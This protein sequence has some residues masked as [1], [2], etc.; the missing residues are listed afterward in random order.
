MPNFPIFRPAYYINTL[1]KKSKFPDINSR[2]LTRVHTYL[3]QVYQSNRSEWN[4]YWKQCVHR[5]VLTSIQSN[6]GTYIN[7][8]DAV[9]GNMQGNTLLPVCPLIY[10][11]SSHTLFINRKHCKIRLSIYSKIWLPKYDATYA[12]FS[13][14]MWHVYFN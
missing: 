4:C 7:S 10:L 3:M 12:P 14:Y 1:L 5:I 2:F 13:N 11:W 6:A 9:D 8:P